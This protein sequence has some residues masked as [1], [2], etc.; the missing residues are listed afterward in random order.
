V[1]TF[2]SD[3][4]GVLADLSLEQLEHDVGFAS[5][6]SSNLP[7]G[8]G[9]ETSHGHMLMR[10]NIAGERRPPRWGLPSVRGLP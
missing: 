1:R 7:I 5:R 6:D 2:P 10:Y 4:F 3:H 8:T 9:F